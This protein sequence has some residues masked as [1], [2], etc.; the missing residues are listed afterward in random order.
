[1]NDAAIGKTV[2]RRRSWYRRRLRLQRTLVAVFVAAVIAGACWQNVAR[3]FSLPVLHASQVL[4]ASFW[5]RG[6]VRN[7]LAFAAASSARPTRFLTRVPGVYPYSVIPGGVRN[8]GDLGNEPVMALDRLDHTLERDQR[9]IIVGYDELDVI[10]GYDW[11]AMVQSIR[12]LISFWA[13][14][15]R[16]WKRIRPKIFLRTDLFRR[17]AQS[18]GADLIKLAA[19]RA[20]ITWSDR[21]LYGMLV[22]RLA[23]ASQDLRHYCEDARVKFK[24][25]DDLALIPVIGESSDARPLIERIAGQY[26]GANFKKGRTF[27]WL[28]THIRDGNGHAMPNHH[29]GSGH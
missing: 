1:L 4:A 17:H 23:N 11:R 22:K 8:L 19:N 5:A 16:R 27:A 6:N 25:D 18:F 12:G 10:G 28:L 2:R 14:N 3:H 21:N 7:N 15:A 24:E 20:E 13:N 9:W 29:Q 26:M